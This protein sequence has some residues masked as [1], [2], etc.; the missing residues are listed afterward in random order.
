MNSVNPASQANTGIT[1][2]VPYGDRAQIEVN[3]LNK[4]VFDPVSGAFAGYTVPYGHSISNIATSGGAGSLQSGMVSTKPETPIVYTQEGAF[5]KVYAP[6]AH[7]DEAEA[8]LANPSAYSRLGAEAYGGMVSLLDGR[9][10]GNITIGEYPVGNLA[11]LVSQTG[12]N[13]SKTTWSEVPWSVPISTTPGFFTVDKSGTLTGLNM[14]QL[15]SIGI[16]P[17][18]P[19]GTLSLGGPGPSGSPKETGLLERADMWLLGLTGMGAQGLEQTGPIGPASKATTAPV[20]NVTLRPSDFD[21]WAMQN[22]GIAAGTLVGMSDFMFSGTNPIAATAKGIGDLAAKVGVGRGGQEDFTRYNI[23]T[24]VGNKSDYTEIS[25]VY[26]SP[27]TT[28]KDLGGGSYEITTLTPVTTT[29]QAMTPTSTKFTPVEGG[30][31]YGAGKFA[32]ATTQKIIP[33]LTY[34]DTGNPV[35]NHL[36]GFGIGMVQGVRDKPIDIALYAGIGGLM[37]A[38]G[39]IVLGLGESTVLATEGMAGWHEAAIATN[40]L[41]NRAAPVILGT[42]YATD[43]A[44]RSTEWFKDF[45]PAASQRFGTILA[46][47]AGPMIIGGALMANRASIYQAG[48]NAMTI[49]LTGPEGGGP[50]GPRVQTYEVPPE[51]PGPSV[52]SNIR[53]TVGDAIYNFQQSRMGIENIG[54][55]SGSE[56]YTEPAYTT[57]A[58]TEPLRIT[59]GEAEPVSYNTVFGE[60]QRLLPEKTSISSFIPEQKT[61]GNF[62]SVPEG[63]TRIA[64]VTTATPEL[65]AS[66]TE[67]GLMVGRDTV[68]LE[69]TSVDLTGNA[70]YPY[71]HM[72]AP[73][74]S[75]ENWLLAAKE[76]Y[77]QGKAGR[78][79]FGSY[80]GFGEDILLFDVPL[81]MYDRVAGSQPFYTGEGTYIGKVTRAELASGKIA[82]EPQVK[83]LDARDFMF[84]ARG[85]VDDALSRPV[86][87]VEGDTVISILDYTRV[88]GV[89][90]TED[91]G[92]E[93]IK[94]RYPEQGEIWNSYR[95]DTQLLEMQPQRLEMEQEPARRVLPYKEPEL[96]DLSALNSIERVDSVINAR[97][98]TVA[99]P[100]EQAMIIAQYELTPGE[101]SLAKSER[102]SLNDILNL[103]AKP[104]FGSNV[105]AIQ[106]LGQRPS[107]EEIGAPMNFD[108]RVEF[109]M[110]GARYGLGIEGTPWEGIS[111]GNVRY[112]P[113]PL[114]RMTSEQQFAAKGK[115]ADFFMDRE[116]NPILS[117]REWVEQEK[118]R[119]SIQSPSIDEVTI[120]DMDRLS[121]TEQ[122]QRVMSLSQYDVASM[123]L[124]GQL[125]DTMVDTKVDQMIETLTVQKPE[126]VTFT[127]T[128]P[129]QKTW[130]DVVPITTKITE[131]TPI[132]TDII[133]PK[134]TTDIIPS[135]MII[136]PIIPPWFPSGGGGGGGF[137]IKGPRK[138]QV[139]TFYI[140][141][142]SVKSMKMPKIPKARRK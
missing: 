56:Y 26:G 90:F 63:Y 34:K 38:G 66:V 107:M 13:Q 99:T 127:D 58:H 109:K 69:Q 134:I 31:E 118:A 97:P 12:V 57:I 105:E 50:G 18:T 10:L 125:P 130:Q 104:E 6:T 29:S 15:S 101:I 52:F 96:I 20:S 100:A 51:P 30:F 103:R 45:S 124:T 68:S 67:K 79:M 83:V 119:L 36:E 43:V 32:E 116:G 8:V 19:V 121:E 14:A 53:N 110:L 133:N 47:E 21:L 93:Y 111:S 77:L 141:P 123:S 16:T 48:R 89:K 75:P 25:K 28:Y 85:L 94:A 81:S 136:P 98:T 54:P 82:E 49:D 112:G 65:I 37:V 139:E 59:A 55:R 88:G 39:E 129:D 78:G 76:T 5:N 115:Y 140:G 128:M 40:F 27:T 72:S 92:M 91:M 120:V 106:S 61:I 95:T 24:S 86:G 17:P 23:E 64:H 117:T 114:S 4:V 42:L 62:P 9:T 33:D 113:E 11:N 131:V 138:R 122:Q 87:Q 2:Y 7:L 41:V 35:L 71:S 22:T 74:A 44:G 142:K 1:L 126:V 84:E 102:F 80:K 3:N 46:T 108:E 73:S 70:P 60:P 135:I 132:T 137:G